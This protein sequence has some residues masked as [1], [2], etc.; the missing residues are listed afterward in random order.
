MLSSIS[1]PHNI[2]HGQGINE[3]SSVKLAHHTDAHDD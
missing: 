1:F 3:T 2:M